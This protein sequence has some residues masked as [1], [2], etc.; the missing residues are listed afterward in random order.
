MNCFRQAA[1]KVDLENVP[2]DQPVG[3]AEMNDAAD[4]RPD[5]ADAADDEYGWAIAC[6]STDFT[7]SECPHANCV[8]MKSDDALR[9]PTCIGFPDPM[10]FKMFGYSDTFS[11]EIYTKNMPDGEDNEQHAAYTSM[12][13]F[14]DMPD[15]EHESLSLSERL[16]LEEVLHGNL[17]FA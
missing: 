14:K 15:I 7:D 1:L 8:F 2:D 5:A 3:D 13:R 10:D 16:I 6:M 12:T 9:A 4:G 17:T 11:E